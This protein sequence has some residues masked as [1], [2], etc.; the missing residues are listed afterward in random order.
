MLAMY[1]TETG[2][3]TGIQAACYYQTQEAM[4]AIESL[5]VFYSDGQRSEKMAGSYPNRP[6]SHLF[7]GQTFYNRE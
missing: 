7:P 6:S 4:T 3:G 2:K 1:K 5:W